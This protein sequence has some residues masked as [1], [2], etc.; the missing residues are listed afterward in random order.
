MAA[1]GENVSAVVS[2]AMEETLAVI[3]RGIVGLRRYAGS[4]TMPGPDRT[5]VDNTSR[6]LMS[7]WGMLFSAK[8]LAQK[9]ER[10]GQKVEKPYS[11]L[12][13]ERCKTLVRVVEEDPRYLAV[14]TLH[15]VFEAV[16]VIMHRASLT[17]NVAIDLDKIHTSLEPC[18][19]LPDQTVSSTP[20]FPYARDE[21]PRWKL[22]R[23]SRDPSPTTDLVGEVLAKAPETPPH[24]LPLLGTMLSWLKELN[25][26]LHDRRLL[27]M[28]WTRPTLQISPAR[29]LQ[30][31]FYRV[32]TLGWF[33]YADEHWSVLGQEIERLCQPETTNN[34]NRWAVEFARQTFALELEG[35]GYDDGDGLISRLAYHLEGG[36]LTPL[37]FAAM[38][39]LSKLCRAL[40][41]RGASVN[42]AGTF[43]S[44][45]CSALI[46]PRL[47]L[48]PGMAFSW[49]HVIAMIEPA[50]PD[51]I[52]SILQAG[53]DTSLMYHDVESGDFC[54]VPIGG[55]AFMA[56]LR[57]DN[58]TLFTSTMDRGV[59]LSSD[60]IKLLEC[61]EIKN[62]TAES[63]G[64]MGKLLWEALDYVFGLGQDYPWDGKRSAVGDAICGFIKRHALPLDDDTPMEIALLRSDHAYDEAV[65]SCVEHGDQYYFKRLIRD[66]R[67]KP[68]LSAMAGTTARGTIIH[69]AV[70]ASQHEML[71]LLSPDQV[72]MTARNT[73][74]WMPLHCVEE[75]VTL[76]VLI[77]HFGVSLAS[78]DLGGRTLLH[79][80]SSQNDYDVVDWLC[81][82]DP[83]IAQNLNAVTEIGRTPLIESLCVPEVAAD[84]EKRESPDTPL[85]AHRLLD[86]PY[87]NC[88]AGRSRL[89]ILHLAVQ[90]GDIELVD[91]LVDRGA[92]AKALG[93]GGVTVFHSLNSSADGE[94]IERLH[95]LSN[96]VPLAAA[97]GRVPL[98][99]I[100][101]NSW[102]TIPTTP[103]IPTI[104]HGRE[105]S[106]HLS[107][108]YEI[109]VGAVTA[110]F[111][112]EFLEYRNAAGEGCWTIWAHTIQDVLSH[113]A[114]TSH[115]IVEEVHKSCLA[116]FVAIRTYRI[117]ERYGQE[118]GRPAVATFAYHMIG[119]GIRWFLE[120]N[121]FIILETLRICHQ[122][123]PVQMD[124]F[125]NSPEAFALLIESL[126]TE[127]F[128][129][130]SF[131]AG[132]MRLDVPVPQ[133]GNLSVLEYAVKC[134]PAEKTRCFCA[135]F[136]HARAYQI[137]SQKKSLCSLLLRKETLHRE[138]KAMLMFSC[139]VS[140][141][142]L[143]DQ[144]DPQ[145]TTCLLAESVVKGYGGLND[146]LLRH[147]AHPTSST[148]VHS[149]G[150]NDHKT[151]QSLLTWNRLDF[152]WRFTANTGHHIL[153][154]AV[155]VC[156]HECLD[157]L[158]AITNVRTTINVSSPVN[159]G[160][161]ALFAARRGCFEC[162]R[163]LDG[164]GADLALVNEKGQTPLHIVC[165]ISPP[166]P[167]LSSHPSAPD[168]VQLLELL[169]G[170]C[171]LDAKDHDG[172]TAWDLAQSH[173]NDDALAV[174]YSAEVDR[175]MREI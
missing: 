20:S 80:A 114:S 68:N 115:G 39:S 48:L 100:Y 142:T 78:T 28:S 162:M 107:C 27:S 61:D 132:N 82:H 41:A 144:S 111:T 23:G 51:I 154:L 40:I 25:S 58:P 63:P 88:H 160:S 120:S 26:D 147:G 104:P 146:C 5:Q 93:P 87:L 131:L 174:L 110:L 64:L 72:D 155:S 59:R 57:H 33:K 49:Q 153:D 30:S 129:V 24:M 19:T 112:Q 95:Q 16:R 99:A 134:L 75:V 119:G 31:N 85:V 10:R 157:L 65:R 81:R 38:L 9:Y 29:D 56:A 143:F 137:I 15:E 6:A 74:G 70:G 36:Q 91:R 124:A 84:E 13:L 101:D 34:F 108:H 77:K 44:A 21:E 50:T 45:L 171:R 118:A 76:E 71:T 14:P 125:Y 158:L 173:R 46:G 145:R 2:P 151:L 12:Y 102:P 135:L 7:T 164:S 136:M 122:H 150:R 130:T 37:H 47:L 96:G 138:E 67:F 60:F 32:A 126:R 148:I 139:G 113:A 83:E 35:A 117:I 1:T 170:R 105:L 53:A 92:D 22:L 156:A 140:P 106:N 97:D 79:M 141:N 4:A 167:S 55:F 86:E 172:K 161:P 166:Y 69:L 52:M 98:Q 103:T 127:E 168:R 175:A 11:Y 152:N 17:C 43:G 3:M 116:G 66:R 121:P 90:W 149:V 169:A 42:M 18:Y 133:L 165:D 163:L 73:D 89:P 109:G 54:N 123:N 159:G 8:W 128:R 62:V 94:F